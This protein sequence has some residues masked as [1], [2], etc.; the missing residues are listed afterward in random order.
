MKLPRDIDAQ[1][2]IRALAKLGYRTTRQS[3]SHIRLGCDSP[4]PHAL[5][6]PNHSPIKPGTLNAILLDVAA[7]H[8]ID[9]SVLIGKLFG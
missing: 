6:I 3:G 4:T 8:R 5:T 7:H 1:Q 2:L 9:K